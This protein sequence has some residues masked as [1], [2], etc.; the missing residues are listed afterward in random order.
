MKRYK[1]FLSVLLSLAMLLG[2]F[3]CAESVGGSLTLRNVALELMGTEIEIGPEV[4]VSAVVEADVL[5]LHVETEN[6]ERTLTPMTAQVNGDG[7]ALFSIGTSG[8]VYSVSPEM[9]LS[10]LDMDEEDMR[11]LEIGTRFI[12]VFSAL[13]DFQLTEENADAYAAMLNDLL[14]TMLSTEAD[15]VQTEIGEKSY[16]MASYKGDI[17]MASAIASL[18]GL[19]ACEVPEFAAYAQL[20][21]D[22]IGLG[23]DES[24]ESFADYADWVN[25]DDDMDM[26][27]ALI[28]AE[29]AFGGDEN[30]AAFVMDMS[31]AA[32]AM[33]NVLSCHMEMAGGLDTQDMALSMSIA[34]GETMGAEIQMYADANVMTLNFEMA[35][36]D[37]Y[38][39]DSSAT[40]AWNAE[41]SEG[42]ISCFDAD[43]HIASDYSDQD[44]DPENAYSSSSTVALTL[45]GA[46]TEGLWK[47]DLDV[48]SASEYNY[49]VD[50]SYAS[51][52]PV[53]ISYAESAEA[54][55]SVTSAIC[56][57]SNEE[58]M[59]TGLKFEVN[60]SNDANIP[61]LSA[62]GAYALTEDTS[63]NAYT[64]LS[65]DLMSLSADAM[66]LLDDEGIAQI[67]SLFSIAD[68]DTADVETDESDFEYDETDDDDYDDDYEEYVDDSVE[69]NALEEAEGI[70]E[71]SMPDF[72]AP[73]EY[74]FYSGYADEDYIDV[75]FIDETERIFN[76]YVSDFGTDM[77]SEEP[78][79]TL[80]DEETGY[81][82]V[83]YMEGSNY[84]LFWFDENFDED[85][86]HRIVAGLNL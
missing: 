31:T 54:D 85:E 18:D 32:E 83:E 84:I 22:M 29:Y 11:A 15:E 19:R 52:T 37:G 26:N 67:I 82:Y 60:V 71:G 41:L 50:E 24:F 64:M 58:G 53:T 23:E 21:L 68:M 69:L 63:S 36:D 65:A 38:G 57:A 43:M 51:S 35:G 73:E 55:G 4:S 59:E 25:S 74:S 13:M 47:I 8:R 16:T 2:V 81:S 1:V 66:E 27:E 80:N 72:T 28:S 70:F 3:A 48:D 10:M 5:R 45:N 86:I 14:G 62:D 12:D 75:Y 6:G 49:G 20:L 33:E 77:G 78:T 42:E 9:L 44:E 40:L 61:A 17:T 7:S 79:F 34:N 46:K 56:I 30:D 76:Y 39:T